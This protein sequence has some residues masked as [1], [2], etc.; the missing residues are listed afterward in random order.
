MTDVIFLD[1]D[2]VLNAFHANPETARHTG[3]KEHSFLGYRLW[4]RPDDGTRLASIAPIVWATTWVTVPELDDVAEA[5]GL[6][7]GLPRISHVEYASGR[8][9]GKLFGVQ[10]FLK[11][12]F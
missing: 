7:R 12:E 8:G 10:E 9:C 6:P 4:L 2:G 3:H 11:K 1:V 5:V